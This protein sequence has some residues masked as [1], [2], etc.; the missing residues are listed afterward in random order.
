[1]DPQ[2]DLT[3]YEIILKL[4]RDHPVGFAIFYGTI[5]FFVL[6]ILV[7]MW[8]L[9][10]GGPRRRRGLRA[11]RKLL[12][13]RDWKNALEQLKKVR[14]IGLPSSAWNKIFDQFE[15]ECLKA[16]SPPPSRT[17]NSRTP[18]SSASAP[19]KSSTRKSTKCA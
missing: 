17:R 8:Q 4:H 9:W 7:G 11:A 5:A 12:A 3:L 18:S 2:Q 15:A 19:R 14:A 6:L 1:M 13:A 10:G 16:A